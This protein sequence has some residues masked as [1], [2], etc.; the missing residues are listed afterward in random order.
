MLSTQG[1]VQ[2]KALSPLQE[3]DKICMTLN[4]AL[5]HNYWQKHDNSENYRGY[6]IGAILLSP[7]DEI[8][9]VGLNTVNQDSDTTRHAEMN[10]IQSFFKSH[11]QA[12]GQLEGYT[13]YTSLEPCTMCTGAI[14]QSNV[15]RVVYGLND[16]EYGGVVKR[17]VSK[18]NGKY[19]FYKT[20][21]DTLKIQKAN[22][23]ISKRIRQIFQITY[24]EAP[25]LV[26]W[27]ETDYVRNL[28]AKAANI[29]LN[30]KLKFPENKQILESALKILQSYGVYGKK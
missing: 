23:N 7:K 16:N 24:T 29:L 6:N 11:P 8:A 30:Y 22:D 26:D 25:S 20:K 1:N 4:Y 3:K 21:H 19:W 2:F 17:L 13:I 28:Y 14:F 5:I 12:C 15:S 10:V 18:N 9:C 27:L